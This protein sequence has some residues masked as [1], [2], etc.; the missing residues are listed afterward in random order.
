MTREAPDALRPPPGEPRFPALDGMRALAAL[1]VLVFHAGAVSF[2]NAEGAL[3]GLTARGDAGVTVF[4]LLSGFLLYRPFVAARLQGRA[5]PPAARF[6]RRRVLRIVPAYWLALVALSIWPGLAGDPLSGGDWWR[7]AFFLQNLSLDTVN[8]GIGPAWT[9]CVELSFYLLLPLYAAGAA[10]L[11]AGRRD[12][13][14]AELALLAAAFAA[15]LALRGVLLHDG[16]RTA[17]TALFTLPVFVTW[18]AVGMALAV[19][20]AERP[21][22]RVSPVA[23]W[24]AALGVLLLLAYAA[25]LPRGFLAPLSTG[26]AL[27]EH[28]GYALLAVLV[29]LPAV[30][31]GRAALVRRVAAN[32][33]AAWLGLVSYGIYLYHLPLLAELA[34]RSFPAL[35]VL[36]GGAALACAAVSYHGLEAPVLRL[37]E[38][39]A[40]RTG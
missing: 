1:S 12:P 22:R 21:E 31:S 33:V 14:R 36:G 6:L 40:R 4:F 29:L 24:A 19:L 17:L 28:A 11:L 26:R 20:S 13:V 38:P 3:G 9:L 23:C 8:Q 10:R 39:R 7:Y 15:S 35:L 27:L 25:G 37:K 2:Y 16:G 30:F 32:P 18:F 34:P 5:G